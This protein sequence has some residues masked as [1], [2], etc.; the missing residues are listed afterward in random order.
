MPSC[1]SA[2]TPATVYELVH[3]TRY[4]YSERVS[5]SHHLARLTPRALPHQQTLEHV[6]DID[7]APAIQSTHTDYFQNVMTFFA[8]QR[9]HTTLT[10]SA[11]SR[12]GVSAP[13]LPS[14]S[15]TPPWDAVSP[16]HLPL[17]A[18]ELTFDALPPHVL[19]KLGEY[20]RPSFTPGRPLLEA[21]LDL[22]ARIHHDF[23][24][25]SDAT[26][27]TT[28]VADF[29]RARRGVCQDFARLGIACLHSLGLAAH[30]V[31]G[32]LE[33]LPAPGR[34]RQIGADASHAWLGVYCPGYG[35]IDVD[36]TNNLLPST[37]HVTLAWGR[38]YGDVSPV[39]GVILGGGEHALEVSV[40]L[41]RAET[42][43]PS[44]AE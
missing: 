30:Y 16:A 22:T 14:A 6:I 20:A 11:R 5:V 21:V 41:V 35:W 3:T 4:A 19:A 12:V 8:M 18:F 42:G 44:P 23:T 1:G 27:V 10:V 9:P 26:T 37:T 13:E 38:D 40:S 7:P 34:P 25:D 33:T 31:S 17:E 43:V 2:D 15:A 28:P 24:F 36:P 39:R 29:F 32:Y